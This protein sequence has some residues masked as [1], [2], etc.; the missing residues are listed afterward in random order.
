GPSRSRF[1]PPEQPTEPPDG[2][3]DRPP[4]SHSQ[5]RDL[6]MT[7]ADSR[8]AAAGVVAPVSVGIDVAKGKLGPSGSAGPD[9]LTVPNDAAGIAELAARLKA[10]APRCIVVEATGGLEAPLV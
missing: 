1:V 9:L 4:R 10:A 8:H 2:P 7:Q 3:P 5:G 6:R